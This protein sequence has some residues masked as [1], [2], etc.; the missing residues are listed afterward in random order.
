MRDTLLKLNILEW[1]GTYIVDKST[2]GYRLGELYRNQP[3][4]VRTIKDDFVKS[5]IVKNRL[6]EAEKQKVRIRRIAHV[7]QWWLH[8]EHIELDKEEAK[9]YLDLYRAIMQRRLPK[10]LDR[11]VKSEK[12]KAELRDSFEAKYWYAM[13]QVERWG[14]R[15]NLTVDGAGGR[16]Y[17]PLV[18]LLSPLRNFVTYK[19]QSLISFDLKNSQPL[20]LLLLLKKDFWSETSRIS[21]S[22]KKLD[23]VLWD[24]VT[25]QET[26]TG[27]S[28]KSSSSTSPSIEFKKRRQKSRYQGVENT[29]FAQL[30]LRGKLYEFN[31][32]KFRGKFF[33]KNGKDRFETRELAKKEMLTLMYFDNSNP[34]SAS[35]EPFQYF[36]QLFP[37]VAEVIELLKS[38]AHRD[39]PVLLQKI[40]AK[41]M[42]EDVCREIYD[43]YPTA[44]FTTVHDSIVT[45]EEYAS[46]VEAII[47]S[48]YRRILGGEPQL[49]RA[50]LNPI[51]AFSKL[52]RY[53]DS[54]INEKLGAEA[55]EEGGGSRLTIDEIKRR[56][57]LKQAMSAT[58]D[59]T[60]YPDLGIVGVDMSDMVNLKHKPN[61]FA[62]LPRKLKK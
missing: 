21:W 31:S 48:T 18:S 8:H 35:Q 37:D 54:K 38:R 57:L 27:T 34:K 7:A 36:K 2:Y 25:K 51:K 4:K 46:E 32:E 30:V 10:R 16:F 60:H 3:L 11:K 13:H 50:P 1:D 22:L 24:H 9:D 12:V 15:P 47:L 59:E 17:N 44:W 20:H 28:D 62:P 52:S 39:F 29:H 42:L 23:P 55:E 53:V 45:T 5:V 33:D 49:E 61:P 58:P 14:K 19:G 43:Q 40:E 26:D 6:Q 41:I 56:L